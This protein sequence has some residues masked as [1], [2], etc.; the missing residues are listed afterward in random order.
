MS[1]IVQN[2]DT[3]RVAVLPTKANAPLVI[4][5]YAVLTFAV[6]FERLQTIR[7]RN[8]EIVETGCVV[9]HTQLATRNLLNVA[10]KAPGGCALPNLFGFLVGEVSNHEPT[11]TEL[12][13]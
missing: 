13:I 11:I 6:A 1:V 10:W 3:M 8:P 12:V 4:D 7:R 9:E 2:F 5:A